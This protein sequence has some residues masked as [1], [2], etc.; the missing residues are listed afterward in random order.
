MAI[1]NSYFDI[2]RDYSL[3]S[4]MLP[5]FG[6]SRIY[7]SYLKTSAP[8]RAFFTAAAS[9]GL[10]VWI[11]HWMHD[12]SDRYL[13]RWWALNTELWLTF[14]VPDWSQVLNASISCT[15]VLW[16]NA[17]IGSFLLPLCVIP[18]WNFIENQ[19]RAPQS[20]PYLIDIQK[21]PWRDLYG[22]Y[23]SL[24]IRRWVSAREACPRCCC[25]NSGDLGC[26]TWYCRCA[27]SIWWP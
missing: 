26:A 13:I 11:Q 1:F 2:T 20:V 21:A 27:A 6:S 15:T 19:S 5:M 10:Q 17:F 4:A 7:W 22:T 14:Y 25:G 24:L 9:G 16:T 8:F 3:S 23:G 12:A 18:N